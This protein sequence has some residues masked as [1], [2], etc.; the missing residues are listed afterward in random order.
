MP[1]VMKYKILAV[2]DHRDTL[3][4]IVMTLNTYG[5]E[6]VYTNYPLEALELAATE[7]PD[8][9]LIDMN[10]PEMSGLELVRR[11]RATPKISNMPIIM[12]TAEDQPHQKKAGF[13]AGVDDYLIKPTPPD[14]M[15]ARIEEMLDGLQPN[16]ATAGQGTVI[17]PPSSTAPVT[18]PPSVPK[19][20]ET[21]P[22]KKEKQGKIAVLGARGGVGTTTVALNLSTILASSGRQTTLVDLDIKHGHVALYLNAQPTKSLTVL[23]ESPK[24][25]AQQITAQ[26]VPYSK[27][28]HLLLAQSN[29]NGRLSS[30]TPTQ[31]NLVLDTLQHGQYV[32]AD[33]GSGIN[34]VTMPIIERADQIVLCLRPERIALISARHLLK[35]LQKHTKNDIRLVMIDVQGGIPKES[36]E[37]FIGHPISTVIPY[38]PE[39][40]NAVNKGVPFTTM[41]PES[42]MTLLLRHFV[43]QMVRTIESN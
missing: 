22:E 16:A 43:K 3:D 5:F 12:F 13:A 41:Y 40:A 10:M 14:E 17:I 9:A 29:I 37:R 34:D 4:I 33:L 35:S 23:A 20:V 19:P 25:S 7:L 42:S 38:A 39:I 11:L 2:D 32:V 30:I 1:I 28:L 21:T 24:P 15:V 31:T 18:I 8:L 36:T 27:R 26:V 6:P